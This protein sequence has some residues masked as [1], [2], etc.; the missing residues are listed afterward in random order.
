MN[1]QGTDPHRQDQQSLGLCVMQYRNKHLPQDLARLQPSRA[2]AL[3]VRGH[4]AQGDRGCARGGAHGEVAPHGRAPARQVAH[5]NNARLR[6][7]ATAT[8]K[9]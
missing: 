4:L 8:T 5:S 6:T 1:A 9:A 2:R 3:T 7:R